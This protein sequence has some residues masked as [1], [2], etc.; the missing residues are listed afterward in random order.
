MKK[1][2]NISMIIML[3]VFIG[4]FYFMIIRPENKKKKEATA[5]IGFKVVISK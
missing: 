5:L 2:V 3:V 4:V 1:I